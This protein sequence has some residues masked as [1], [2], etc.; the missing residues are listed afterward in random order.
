MSITTHFSQPS[1]STILTRPLQNARCT[2]WKP[3]PACPQDRVF[4]DSSHRKLY[5]DCRK[6]FSVCARIGTWEDGLD[7]ALWNPVVEC[8]EPAQWDIDISFNVVA[9]QIVYRSAIGRFVADIPRELQSI[10]RTF[11][12]RWAVFLKLA[13]YDLKAVVD[14]ACSNPALA[15]LMADSIAEKQLAIN[16]ALPLLRMKRREILAVTGGC[17]TDATVN[18][19][20]KIK[21]TV[22]DARFALP[23]FRCPAE[24]FSID[25]CR[26][27][28]RMV[29]NEQLLSAL[30]HL[31][32]IPVWLLDN[33]NDDTD[34]TLWQ[35]RNGIF[36]SLAEF[37]DDAGMH[38]A[39]MHTWDKA[40]RMG[41]TA[42]VPNP[43]ERLMRCASF[44][45]IR[46]L[47][48]KWN[49]EIAKRRRDCL[50]GAFHLKFGTTRFGPPPISGNTSIIP[51]ETIDDL[52]AE[53]EI[54]HH[55]IAEYGERIMRG[56]CYVYRILSPERATVELVGSEGWWRIG[57]LR[58]VYNGIVTPQTFKSVEKWFSEV[59]R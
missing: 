14:L 9:A 32:V 47:Y 10:L 50:I 40:V 13:R 42:D 28:R 51:I 6:S 4:F 57:Q 17:A 35:I 12:W 11:S 8:W 30:R 54:M 41:S 58:G 44:T 46:R 27:I 49:S 53:A 34:V 56:E 5:I 20:R 36:A 31:P 43:V 59:I 52:Y 21:A 3:D 15:L 37:P 55:C 16:A 7:I 48:D 29:E 2:T 23:D 1:R 19:L 25:V 18:L 24:T 26:E 38:R 22:P 45:A 33:L 39:I